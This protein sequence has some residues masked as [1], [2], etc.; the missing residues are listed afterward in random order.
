MIVKICGIKN[1]KELEIV[2][3]YADF[4]GVVVRSESRRAVDFKVAREIIE[5]ASVPIF[6]VSTAS[7][8]E[9]WRGIIAKTNCDFVQVHGSMSVE[10]FEELKSEVVAMKSFIVLRDAESIVAEVKLYR[11][12]YVLLDSGCGSGRVHDWS[13]SREVARKFPV[14]LAGGLNSD[15]VAKAIE[16]VKPVGVDVSSSVERNG[17]KDEFLVSEFVRVVKNAIR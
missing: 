2:E 6:V 11:P 1:S 12:H 5:N 17:F 10:E 7:R 3:R 4:G 15:N 9:E 14:I 8:I 16:F 13:V